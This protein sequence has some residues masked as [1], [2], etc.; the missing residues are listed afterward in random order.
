MCEQCSTDARWLTSSGSRQMQQGSSTSEA[1][2]LWVTMWEARARVARLCRLA[3]LEFISSRVF[4]GRNSVDPSMLRWRCLTS[5]VYI[6]RCRPSTL[7]A[8]EE[9]EAFALACSSCIRYGV[10]RRECIISPGSALL[11]IWTCCLPF[12]FFFLFFFFLF[13]F[14]ATC[15]STIRFSSSERCI[16]WMDSSF[17]SLKLSL[18]SPVM[19]CFCRIASPCCDEEEPPMHTHDCRSALF[20]FSELKCK[21]TTLWT[22]D[23]VHEERLSED[24]ANTPTTHFVGAEGC[25]MQ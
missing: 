11:S 12:F 4:S 10:A 8:E 16:L 18:R 21:L 13:C 20:T 23:D 14:K 2:W 1:A 17:F 25:A 19:S 3:P 7:E 15:S 24:I 5:A 6:M 22:R 9:E